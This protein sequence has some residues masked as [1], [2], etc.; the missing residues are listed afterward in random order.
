MADDNQNTPLDFSLT[1]PIP[2]SQYPHVLMAHGGGGKLMH[3]LIEK[4][5][6][7]TFD[8]PTLDSRHDGAVFSLGGARLAFTT[9]SYVIHPLFFPGGDIGSMAVHGTV[10]DLAMCGAKPLYL[11]AGFI[12]EEGLPMDTLWQV[13]NSM[14]AAAKEA[15]VQIATGDT[16]VVDRGKGDGI[17]INTA[18]VGVIEHDLNINP[19]S[20]QVGDAVLISGDIGRHGIAIMAQREGLAFETTI[21]SDSAAVAGLVLQLIDA[22]IKVHCLRDLTRGGLATTMIEIAEAANTHIHLDEKAIPVREDVRGACE[23]L[24]FDPMYVANEGRFAAFVKA[25]DAEQALEIM[26]QHPLGENSAIIGNVTDERPGMVTLRSVIGA[27]R[28]IDM[29]SGEQLPRIC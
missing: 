5:F 22:G 20:V 24:G 29:L 21:E 28:I 7:Q 3:N 17:F 19:D 16:K 4:M 11:S 27:T 6:I 1:C 14:Q 26:R 13:V 12:I 9:D 10:N 18:G 2:I 8:N 25:A 23:I 15:G